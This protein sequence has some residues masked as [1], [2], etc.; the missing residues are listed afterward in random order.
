[1]IVTGTVYSEFYAE[2]LLIAGIKLHFVVKHD[3]LH[4]I[5]CLAPAS[6]VCLAYGV[7]VN[8]AS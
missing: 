7:C 5:M 2:T 6:W 8:S 3:A 1:M 4:W